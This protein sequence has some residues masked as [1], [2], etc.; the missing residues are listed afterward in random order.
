MVY[1]GGNVKMRM[2]AWVEGF[3]KEDLSILIRATEVQAHTDKGGENSGD[4]GL[5]RCP[6][7]HVYA[8]F[9]SL[10]WCVCVHVR[11]PVQ[12]KI[13]FVTGLPF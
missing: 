5:G 11:N 4:L 12:S 7:Q 13:L 9:I 6:S 8:V 1:N 3:A 2:H 10:F